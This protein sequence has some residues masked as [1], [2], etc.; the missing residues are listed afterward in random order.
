M[1]LNT[2]LNVVSHDGWNKH[3]WCDLVS[4]V[5]QLFDVMRPPGLYKGASKYQNMS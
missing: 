3:D 5:K 2:I 1:V 4:K